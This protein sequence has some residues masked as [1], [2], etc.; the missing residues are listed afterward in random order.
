MNTEDIQE[1]LHRLQ[2]EDPAERIEALYELHDREPVEDLPVLINLLS[3]DPDP[4]VRT[5]AVFL[6][7][8][9]SNQ[10][11]L[12]DTVGIALLEAL[13]DEYADLRSRAAGTLGALHYL[14]AV[15]RLQMLAQDD[16]EWYV[17]T[18]AVEALGRIKDEAS[19]PIIEQ[20][21]SDPDF[22]V[23]R[24]AVIAL[25]AFKNLPQV[26]TFVEKQLASDKNH[27]LVQAELLSLS[28]RMGNYSRLHKLL[29]LLENA[30]NDDMGDEMLNVLI[31]LT[32]EYAVADVRNQR[33]IIE[34]SLQKV[35]A[36]Y[37]ILHLSVESVRRNLTELD[38]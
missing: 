28:Y 5:E 16:K 6:L 31:N 9:F 30:E 10:S 2:L 13:N 3:T 25:D 26:A 27:P 18:S 8:A 34:A 29:E 4:D 14:P 1:I 12:P 19:L 7:R 17:R 37:P 33:D 36:E 35:L 38:K 15:K 22:E 24:Y 21:I 20:V 23:G 11:S 32:G